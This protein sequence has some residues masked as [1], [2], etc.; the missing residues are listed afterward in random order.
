VGKCLGV[1]VK[2]IETIVGSNPND[3]GLVNEHR[4]D[5]IIAQTVWII[6]LV[7]ENRN[8]MTIKAIEAA[9]GSNPDKALRILGHDIGNGVAQA[10]PNGQMGKYQLLLLCIHHRDR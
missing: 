6:R 4:F 10:V 3:T 7:L 9:N 2:F 1:G 8:L 5:E